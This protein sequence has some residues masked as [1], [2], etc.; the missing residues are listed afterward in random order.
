MNDQSFRAKVMYHAIAAN[1][2]YLIVRFHEITSAQIIF[3]K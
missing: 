2:N 1:E 3:R